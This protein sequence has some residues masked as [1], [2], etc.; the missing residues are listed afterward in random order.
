MMKGPSTGHGIKKNSCTFPWYSLTV[1]SD[2]KVY[3][4]PQDF[5]GAMPVGDINKSSLKDIFNGEPLME[6]RNMFSSGKINKKLPCFKC[7][8]IIRKSFFGIPLE[9]AGT[10]FRD[11]I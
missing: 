9:Y 10:F 8:R 4:C 3:P 11:N 2:G 6:L 7:D 1:F 5:M